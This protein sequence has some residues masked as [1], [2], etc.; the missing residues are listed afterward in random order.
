MFLY[1][2][3]PGCTFRANQKQFSSWN[4]QAVNY[5]KMKIWMSCSSPKAVMC[6]FLFTSYPKAYKRCGMAAVVQSISEMAL[7]DPVP[8][9]VLRPLI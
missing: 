9:R 7:L 2:P 1:Y 5:R 8:S 6:T 3:L 4:N